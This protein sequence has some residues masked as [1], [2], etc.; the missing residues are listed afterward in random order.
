MFFVDSDVYVDFLSWSWRG[1]SQ[2]KYQPKLGDVIGSDLGENRVF[3]DNPIKAKG[4][5]F[6]WE[7][8]WVVTVCDLRSKDIWDWECQWGYWGVLRLIIPSWFGKE[9]SCR[10][11]LWSTYVV[12]A[13]LV[14]FED[15]IVYGVRGTFP[16]KLKCCEFIDVLWFDEKTAIF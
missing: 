8:S 16:K 14:D 3:I 12:E 9:K 15:D 6:E 7:C 10:C 4:S 13:C 1:C 2:E 11:D 5:D